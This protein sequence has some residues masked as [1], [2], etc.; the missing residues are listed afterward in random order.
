[1]SDPAPRVSP[2]VLI[3]AASVVS[4]ATGYLVTSIVA[5]SVGAAA[6]AGFAVFWSALFI[7]TGAFG[8]LQQEYTRASGP[9]QS[10][11]G[12]R[13]AVF[14]LSVAASL[15]AVLAATSPLWNPVVL[16]GAASLVWPL[17]L[18][19][20][21]Y[22]LVAALAG[23]LYGVRGWYPL[24]ALIAL[25]GLLRLAGVLLVLAL[26]GGV[27]ELAWAV[28][29]PFPLAIAI[30]LPFIARGLV[31]QVQLDV[32]YRALGWNTARTVLAA[33]GTATLISGFPLLLR[34][35]SPDA[36]D[37][38]LGSL[39][40]AL[41]LTRAPI[42]IP[43][44]S[45]QSY[46]VVHFGDH[47]EAVGRRALRLVGAVLAGALLLAGLAA[48]IGPGIL[49]ALFGADFFVEPWVLFALV[50]SSGLVAALCVSGP[51]VLSRAQHGVYV[52]G[53]I[54]ASL[55]TIAL[56]L[57]PL[58]LEGRTTLALVGGPL[59][60]LAVHLIALARRR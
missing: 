21:S 49:V 48:W 22:V 3:L 25:D 46:L 51:A 33:A 35:T 41:T 16:P 2:A 58:P 50:A 5:A 30:V 44:L 45:L 55:V 31:G 29:L 6:Y 42:V 17:A 34:I 43:L 9:R 37:A 8:G 52:G 28:A 13:P 57:L 20:A 18:G 59:V 39:V 53:W 32:G 14:A 11:G 19:A 15:F 38:A 36:P 12:A 4:G 54:A 23:V 7:L 27:A 24:V 47:V 10:Q 40:L 1:M 60:G 56:L 26:G